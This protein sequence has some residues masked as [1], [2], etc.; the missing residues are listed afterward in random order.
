M[1]ITDDFNSTL[2][3]FEADLKS[4]DSAETL[5]V[6][7]IKY[8]GKK[9]LVT[10]FSKKIGYVPPDERRS[11]G[12]KV[13]DL[14]E[15]VHTDL[16][17]LK[18]KIK[19]K[20]YE[21]TIKSKKLDVHLP[22]RSHNIGRAHPLTIVKEEILSQFNK[23]GFLTV[24]GPEIE[25]DYYNFEALNIPKD[26]PAR[27]V[28]DSFY[29]GNDF[30]LRT[31]TSPVQIHIMEKVRPPLAIVSPGRVYRRDTSDSSHSPIFH[32]IEGLFVDRDVTM[33]DLKGTLHHFLK[34]FFG[35]KVEIRFRPDY[36]PFTE[37]SCEIAIS[38]VMCRG[39]GCST[40]GGDGWIEILGA[41]LVNPVVLKNVN[42][43]PK[44]YCGFA[45]GLGVERIAMIKYGIDDIRYFYENHYKFLRQFQC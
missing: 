18:D 3:Q 25:K 5:T 27:D 4:I 30:L 29:L 35:D 43:D 11:F 10:R 37:P 14:K 9:G 23:M 26:H 24:E 42:I 31:Q 12:Q 44:E 13:H 21:D 45:F 32:Q 1:K 15:R 7:K 6:L 2:I 41:G 36:F 22:G 20:E 39:S 40:C 19:N 16:E 28:Q 17:N 34:M 8:L 33:A 38:C